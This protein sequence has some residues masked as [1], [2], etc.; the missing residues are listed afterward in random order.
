MVPFEVAACLLASAA[1]IL[2]VASAVKGG[3]RRGKCHSDKQALLIFLRRLQLDDGRVVEHKGTKLHIPATEQWKELVLDVHG[4]S[5][6]SSPQTW[7]EVSVGFAQLC[8]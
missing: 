7:Q 2:R 6:F 5:H 1:N 3:L 8:A 4:A